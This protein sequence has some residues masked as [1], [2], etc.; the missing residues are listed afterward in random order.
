M[1]L[2]LYTLPGVYQST[3]IEMKDDVSMRYEVDHDNDI[4][5]LYFGNRE[6]YVITIGS[7]NLGQFVALALAAKRELAE[8]H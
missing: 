3:W 5:T 4:A 2:S 6:E 7:N 1:S 8:T